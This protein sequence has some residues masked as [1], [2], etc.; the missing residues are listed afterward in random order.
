[1][2]LVLVGREN[3]KLAQTQP[4]VLWEAPK[5]V[6]GRVADKVVREYLRVW[7]LATFKPAVSHVPDGGALTM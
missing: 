4:H 1:M 3:N 7:A 2:S 5:G 6:H